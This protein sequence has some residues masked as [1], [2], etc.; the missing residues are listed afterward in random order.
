MISLTSL[1][2]ANQSA[3][4][5]ELIIRIPRTGDFFW[6]GAN[7]KGG[8]STETMSALAQSGHAE[9]RNLCRY[10]GE[11]DMAYCNEN[12]RL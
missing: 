1:Q 10:W 3:A 8:E 9:N 11:A 5:T 4:L 12:V 6:A 7:G 2:S